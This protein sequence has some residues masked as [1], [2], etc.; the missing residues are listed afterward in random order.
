[1]IKNTNSK[2]LVFVIEILNLFGVWYL[3]FG[4]LPQNANLI[5]KVFRYSVL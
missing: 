2:Q 5:S 1:M 3:F 4:F